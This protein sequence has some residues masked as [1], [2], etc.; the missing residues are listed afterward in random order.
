MIGAPN[1]AYT[2]FRNWKDLAHKKVFVPQR[3]AVKDFWENTKVA[4]TNF[5]PFLKDVLL[6]FRLK[7]LT[8]PH[9]INPA[10]R[11]LIDHLDGGLMRLLAKLSL[12]E[13][14]S[15]PPELQLPP[16]YPNP[17]EVEPNSYAKESHEAHIVVGKKQPSHELAVVNHDAHAPLIT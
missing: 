10:I 6:P 5:F 17:S 2:V 14:D 4:A 1:C 8:L 16:L 13:C 11:S 3:N 12:L 7:I 15:V 9:V